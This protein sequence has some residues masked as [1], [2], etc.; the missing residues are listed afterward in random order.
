VIIPTPEI[1]EPGDLPAAEMIRLHD[2]LEGDPA[3]SSHREAWQRWHAWLAELAA[4]ADATQRA[5]AERIGAYIAATFEPPERS[6]GPKAAGVALIAGSGGVAGYEVG[7]IGSEAVAGA[8][9]GDDA[10]TSGTG[11]T[12]VEPDRA[13]DADRARS[14][15][16]LTHKPRRRVVR[17]SRS[18]WIGGSIVVVGAVIAG[19]VL[20]AITASPHRS[21][22]GA[23]TITSSTVGNKGAQ[24]GAYSC[25]GAV[26]TLLDTYNSGVPSND[27]RAPSFS[28]GGKPYCL[29]ELTTSHWNNGQGAPAGTVTLVGGSGPG[30]RRIGPLKLEPVSGKA[31]D[32]NL[33]AALP[34]AP[35]VVIDG[36]Y[37]VSDSQPSTWSQNSQSQG[38]G[39]TR[40]WVRAATSTSHP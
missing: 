12:D 10:S 28:T 37:T 20:G 23:A 2:E 38:L 3:S 25:A 26:I 27:G 13:A 36:T 14:G 8:T 34:E 7:Q 16:R 1:L 24:R 30:A 32:I 19:V 17:S 33:F 31:V 39:F 21:S 40:V 4:G 6:T 29:Y 5:R 35:P 11:A 18:W 15:D 22:P 9:P